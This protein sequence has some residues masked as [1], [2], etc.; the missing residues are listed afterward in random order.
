MMLSWG[1]SMV[2]I[3]VLL[4]LS[5]CLCLPESDRGEGVNTGYFGSCWSAMKSGPRGQIMFPKDAL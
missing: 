3:S 1:K 5:G 4:S 2:A